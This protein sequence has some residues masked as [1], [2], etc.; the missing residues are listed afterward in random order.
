M[1]YSCNGKYNIL[2]TTVTGLHSAVIFPRV[3]WLSQHQTAGCECL[4]TLL[5]VVVIWLA[6]KGIF[7]QFEVRCYVS[8]HDPENGM[9]EM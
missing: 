2:A 5:F 1:K 8:V 7:G 4:M 9:T 3:H 6:E